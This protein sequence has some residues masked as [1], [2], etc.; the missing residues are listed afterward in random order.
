MPMHFYPARQNRTGGV[1]EPVTR[2]RCRGRAAKKCAACGGEVNDG[3]CRRHPT[4]NVDTIR[5]ALC[6]KPLCFWHYVLQP[7]SDPGGH[8]VLVQKCFPDCAHGLQSPEHRP[9]VA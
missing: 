7:T 8:V 2:C 1:I 5:C 4:A 3:I 6:Q 9:R